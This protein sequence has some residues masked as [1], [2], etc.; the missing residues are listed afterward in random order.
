MIIGTITVEAVLYNAQSL[1][2]KRSVIKS[3]VTRAKQ[4]NVSIIESNHQ[5]VWQRTEWTIVSVGS[6][7]TQ[8]EKELKRALSIIE[9]NSDLEVTNITWEWY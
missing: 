9:T 1:K 5:D 2:E 7:R 6:L 8:A 4:Y 3:I